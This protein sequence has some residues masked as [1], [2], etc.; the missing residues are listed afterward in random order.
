MSR[1]SQLDGASLDAQL[2][3][4]L[5]TELPVPCPSLVIETLVF[6]LGTRRWHQDSVGT[7]GSVLTGVGYRC[8]RWRL[9]A[10]TVLLR[11][12]LRQVRFGRTDVVYEVLDLV[13]LL[14]FLASGRGGPSLLHRVLGISAVF[15]PGFDYAALSSS[16][17]SSSEVQMLWNAAVEMIAGMSYRPIRR[18]QAANASGSS[19]GSNKSTSSSSGICPA[20]GETATNAQ[21][22]GCCSAKYCY[23]CALELEHSRCLACNAKNI[24]FVCTG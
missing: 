23:I 5:Q 14:G 7:Y 11:Q 16:S 13:H 6:V 18:V 1:V 4:A 2:A 20:C 21:N 9:F 22:A 12:L 10:A 3:Q 8:S 19:S 17:S 15:D 24:T